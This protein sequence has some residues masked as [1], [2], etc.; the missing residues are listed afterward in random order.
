MPPRQPEDVMLILGEIRGQL[1]E[2]IHSGNNN[3]QKLDAL[4]L[5][6]AALEGEQARRAGANGLVQAILKSPLLA[7][8][9]AAIVAVMVWLK[10]HRL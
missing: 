8:I 10:D 6:V 1:R 9:M 4:A 5:R 2:L 3:S 7:W